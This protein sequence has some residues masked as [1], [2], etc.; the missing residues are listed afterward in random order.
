[1]SLHVIYNMNYH[2]EKTVVVYAQGWTSRCCLHA[3]NNKGTRQYSNIFLKIWTISKPKINEIACKLELKSILCS[4]I[5]QRIHSGVLINKEPTYKTSLFLKV[6]KI[7]FHDIFQ[8]FWWGT[9][10]L[11]LV[12]VTWSWIFEQFKELLLI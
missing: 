7:L 10:G 2:V 3:R 8:I 5:R 4:H 12:K 1:M 6:F 9:W 11:Q